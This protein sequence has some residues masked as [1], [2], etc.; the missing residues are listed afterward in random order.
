M[1]VATRELKTTKHRPEVRESR[2]GLE[3]RRWFRAETADPLEAW[4]S[5]PAEYGD[6]WP[7]GAFPALRVR[8][9]VATLDTAASALGGAVPGTCIVEVGYA[10]DPPGQFEIP[11]EDRQP[12]AAYTVFEPGVSTVNVRT[13]LEGRVI[14]RGQG[15][16]VDVPSYVVKVTSYS[17]APPPVAALLGLRGEQGGLVVNAGQLT[18]PPLY[19]ASAAFTFEPGEVRFVSWR[20]LAFDEETQ[21]YEIE[22]TFAIA[23]D[24]KFRWVKEDANGMAVGDIIEST[25]YEAKAFPALWGTP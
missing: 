21:A 23:Q 19:R 2:G 5:V 12:G 16:P 24:H 18:I 14:A 8:S 17:S 7:G 4:A 13:D 11:P 3:G 10:T 6:P 15:A 20:L 25:V 9:K 22:Y 1:G